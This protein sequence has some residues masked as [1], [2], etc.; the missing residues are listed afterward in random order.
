LGS[1]LYGIGGYTLPFIFFGSLSMAIAI[2]VAVF[3]GNEE[4]GVSNLS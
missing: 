2:I 1:I 3:I 4:V